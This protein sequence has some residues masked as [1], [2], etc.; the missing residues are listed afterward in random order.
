MYPPVTFTIGNYSIV[1]APNGNMS[2]SEHA[3]G[4]TPG[5][6][7][8]LIAAIAQMVAELLSQFFPPAPGAN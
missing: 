1:L 5:Q 2:A 4:L 3:V 8:Q 7:A 6:W